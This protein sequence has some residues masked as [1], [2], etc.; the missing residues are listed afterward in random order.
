MADQKALKAAAWLEFPHPGLLTIG[1]VTGKIVNP[2]GR[3]YCTIV[4]P[5]IPSPMSGFLELA[6]CEEVTDADIDVDDAI[7]MLVSG[8][9]LAPRE[10]KIPSHSSNSDPL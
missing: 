1:F 9:I 3:P 2:A 4:V 5:T 10:L 6:P 7:K 8:G